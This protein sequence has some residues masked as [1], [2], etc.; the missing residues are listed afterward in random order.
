MDS[1][2]KAAL[3]SQLNTAAKKYGIQPNSGINW[4]DFN[5]PPLLKLIHYKRNE[6]SN[7]HRYMATLLWLSH[8]LIFAISIINLIN[9]IV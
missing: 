3:S 2:G 1:L 6:L 8:I 5:Y 4:N 7:P 9:N